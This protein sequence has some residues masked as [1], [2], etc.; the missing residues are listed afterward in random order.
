[1]SNQKEEEVLTPYQWGRKIY[2]WQQQFG[3]GSLFCLHKYGDADDL[4]EPSIQA[5]VRYPN[6]VIRHEFKRK[7]DYVGKCSKCG[8]VKGLN[9]EIPNY[10]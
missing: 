4:P 9:N 6:G 1:M 8:K 3:G 7:G 10:F 5:K 2:Y